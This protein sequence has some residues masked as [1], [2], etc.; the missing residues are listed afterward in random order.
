MFNTP[1][2]SALFKSSSA[3][4]FVNSFASSSCLHLRSLFYT[5][6][7]LLFIISQS[8]SSHLCFCQLYNFENQHNF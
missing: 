6:H 1:A 7:L 2:F 4:F 3:S 8:H 5:S